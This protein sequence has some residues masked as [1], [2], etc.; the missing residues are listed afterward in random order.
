MVKIKL[1]PIYTRAWNKLVL[2]CS[3]NKIGFELIT[4]VKGY[5]Y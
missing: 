5:N 3:H 2:V 4:K 1:V